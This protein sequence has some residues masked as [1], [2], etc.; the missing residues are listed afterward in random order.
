MNAQIEKPQMKYE[1]ANEAPR[2][3]TLHLYVRCFDEI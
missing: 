3:N 1:A 2:E